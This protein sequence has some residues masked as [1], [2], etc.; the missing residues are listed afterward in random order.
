[1]L[2]PCPLFSQSLEVV[3]EKQIDKTADK[4][5]LEIYFSASIKNISSSPLNLALKT[6]VKKLTFG[7]SYDVC[8]FYLCNP[9][10][11][12]SWVGNKSQQLNPGEAL[13][14]N[15]FYAHYYSFNKNTDPVEGEGNIVFVFYNESKPDDKVEID[16]KYKFVDG[17]SIYEVFGNPNV[18]FSIENK[19][20]TIS[21]KKFDNMNLQIFDI[22]GSLL[23][24]ESFRGGYYQNN[25]NQLPTGS[26]FIKIISDNKIISKGKFILN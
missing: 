3:G 4:Q 20:I 5:D 6:E 11:T 21:S 13:P 24:S 10:T 25:L 9:P 18:D 2:L 8:W 26:Y 16:A 14:D 15:F 23:S 17:M 7:H 1:M 12:E 19:I 22:N